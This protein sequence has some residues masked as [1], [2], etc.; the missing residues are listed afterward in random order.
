MSGPARCIL[1][2]R[3]SAGPR[4]RHGRAAGA[5]HH[6]QKGSITSVQAIYV[7]AD[8]LTDPAPATS[9]AQKRPPPCCRG[10]SPGWAPTRRSA[11][12]IQPRED[13]R[14][15][16]RRRDADAQSR[17][18]CS[19]CCADLQ[20]AYQD[21]IAILD[22]D[23]LSEDDEL[24]VS[25]MPARSGASCRQP[26]TMA[27]VFT[28]SPGVLSNPRGLRSK[29]FKGIVALGYDEMQRSSFSLVGTI[30]EAVEKARQIVAGEGDD[31]A[32]HSSSPGSTRR[33][34]RRPGRMT[35]SSPAMTRSLAR[36]AT[37][38]RSRA[39]RAGGTPERLVTGT[40]V[41]MV[42]VE[43]DREIF[44]RAAEPTRR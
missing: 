14:P 30:E 43:R 39:I 13:A 20:I 16:R 25:Q 9:F 35:E 38:G 11:R 40:L 21:I 5:H 6:H 15:L 41:E 42:V 26:F 37:D 19:A 17:A 1:G 24:T 7:P 34:R 27:E 32:P 23:E 29:G 12:S 2:G 10:R 4:H 18:T 22:M 31:G 3:L 36:I 8:D 44:R 33:S 28:G